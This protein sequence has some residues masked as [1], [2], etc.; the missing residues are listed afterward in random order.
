M[1]VVDSRRQQL[2]VYE[3]ATQQATATLV[4]LDEQA[5]GGS[6]QEDLYGFDDG[7]G[8]TVGNHPAHQH[9]VRRRFLKLQSN[10]E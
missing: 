4:R 8:A 10:Q 3:A 9:L 2:I 5:W 7:E 1:S 6:K